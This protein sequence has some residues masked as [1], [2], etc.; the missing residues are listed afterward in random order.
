[1]SP[2]TRPVARISLAPATKTDARAFSGGVD[3]GGGVWVGLNDPSID[4]TVLL[5]SRLAKPKAF[6]LRVARNDPK[7]GY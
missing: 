6:A 2:P 3:L 4:Q 7:A 1:M 5:A